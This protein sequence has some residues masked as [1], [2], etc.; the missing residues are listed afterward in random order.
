MKRFIFAF[1]A[2]YIFMFIWGWLLNGVVLKDVYAQWQN[3]FRSRDEMMSLFHWILIGQALLI[4]AFLMI[5]ANGFAGGGVVAGIKL[6]LMLELAAIG[7]R[8]AIY[9]VQPFPGQMIVYGSIGGV[10]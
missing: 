5:Y 10:I 4:L 1:I 9:A 6:G 7:M 2:A 3:L 8:M